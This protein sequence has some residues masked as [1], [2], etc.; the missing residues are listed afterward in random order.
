[1]DGVILSRDN[2]GDG[3]RGELSILV[4]EFDGHIRDDRGAILRKFTCRERVDE[5]ADIAH[6]TWGSRRIKVEK[7]FTT[8]TFYGKVTKIPRRWAWKRQT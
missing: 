5:L 8:G 4:L 1:M 6:V 3:R 2:E 7:A